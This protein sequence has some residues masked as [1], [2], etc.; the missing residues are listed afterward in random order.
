MDRQFIR[1]D[2]KNHAALLSARILDG[3]GL[4]GVSSGPASEAPIFSVL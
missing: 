3:H 2:E 1:V 4:F